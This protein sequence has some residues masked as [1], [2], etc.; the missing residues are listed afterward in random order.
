[1][2]PTLRLGRVPDPLDNDIEDDPAGLFKSSGEAYRQDVVPLSRGEQ[3]ASAESVQPSAAPKGG[4][5]SFDLYG[6][7]EQPRA[8]PA[9]KAEPRAGK[10]QFD[11]YGNEPKPEAEAPAPKEPGL[12]ISGGLKKGFKGLAVTWDFLANKLEKAVT[13]SDEDT[14]QILAKSA[15]EYRKLES[16]PRIAELVRK[17][18]AAPRHDVCGHG[19]VG[20]RR[21]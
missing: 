14:G 1:M 15:D 21:W 6:G 11:L 10:F 20:L 9:P 18:D 2:Q 16:D 5:F 3:V 8:Q 12:D 17:G 4:K 7:A 13:G 19:Y